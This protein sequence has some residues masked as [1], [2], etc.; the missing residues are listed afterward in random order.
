MVLKCWRQALRG[1][2]LEISGGGMVSKAEGYTCREP[3]AGAT[4]E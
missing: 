4:V 3:A 2:G 1:L